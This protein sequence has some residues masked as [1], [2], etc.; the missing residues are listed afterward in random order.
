M[1]GTQDVEGDFGIGE[2]TIPEVV[3]KVRVGEKTEMMVFACPYC[4]PSL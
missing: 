3:R 4:L 1:P 2:E